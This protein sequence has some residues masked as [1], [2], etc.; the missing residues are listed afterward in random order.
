[1]VETPYLAELL[2]YRSESTTAPTIQ[3]SSARLCR[4]DMRLDA[5]YHSSDA[6][7]AQRLLQECGYELHELG[8]L[9]DSISYP[10][11]FKR[12]YASREHGRP[13]LTAS[14]MMQFR[15]ESDVSLANLQ[16][17]AEKC[18][19]Q[20][21]SILITR[22]GSVGRCVLV[23][24][25]LARFAISDDALRV[26]SLEVP[27]GY[28]YAFLSS[29]IGQA[30]L[31]KS[32]YGS[33][34]KH[35]EPHHAT[36]IPVPVLPLSDLQ[37]IADR[38]QTA[39]SL[40]EKANSLLDD[41]TTAFYTGFDLPPFDES[42]VSYLSPKPYPPAG[43]LHS[44]AVSSADIGNR[45]DASYHVPI[46]E[47]AV[48]V[49]ESGRYKPVAMGR[50]CSRIFHPG[51]FKRNYVSE[52]YGVPFMQGSH[53]PLMKPYG[54]KYLARSDE[55]NISRCKITSGWVLMTC[56]G[57]V[58]RVGMVSSL[59]DGWAA[60]QHIIRFVAKEPEYNPGYLALFLMTPYGQH[61][62]T[63]RVYGAVVDELASDDASRI[64][65]PD[66]PREI[67]DAVGNPVIK[68]FEYKD[69]A[70]LLEDDAIHA[71]EDRLTKTE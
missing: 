6:E 42:L 9:C 20:K 22:S 31:T 64:M 44:F 21:S 14:K 40:R 53:I 61:Q 3:L 57:T 68:A 16:G 66:P 27:T 65:I 15:P 8:N 67:Q 37:E 39:Y 71:L 54:L 56:S 7:Q 25:R 51:R 55:R 38:V 47:T 4:G 50:I 24:D 70:N 28:L 2:D 59:T 35:L 11:R 30:L 5:G 13:F 33:A 34:V 10:G 29:W 17:Q 60:S 48:S 58:G 26:R 52:R 49:M 36:S 45:L 12:I 41:A 63:S 62:V 32:Q 23:G 1:M 69:R 18:A 19:V 46:V 43:V